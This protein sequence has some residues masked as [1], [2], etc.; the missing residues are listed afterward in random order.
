[1]I[2]ILQLRSRENKEQKNKRE[3]EFDQIS[4]MLENTNEPIWYYV[5]APGLGDCPSN[6]YI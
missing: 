6:F 3:T 5:Y 4:Q 1:M 2:N